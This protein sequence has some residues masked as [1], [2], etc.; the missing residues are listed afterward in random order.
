MAAKHQ[1]NLVVL[2][3]KLLPYHF[4]VIVNGIHHM[5]INHRI[6]LSFTVGVEVVVRGHNGWQARVFLHHA[7]GPFQRRVGGI[8]LESDMEEPVASRLEYLSAV[9]AAIVVLHVPGFVLEKY[10]ISAEDRPEIVQASGMQHAQ[11]S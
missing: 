4:G 9:G 1:E 5:T 7:G 8:E 2:A 10:R 3:N 6:G 11:S